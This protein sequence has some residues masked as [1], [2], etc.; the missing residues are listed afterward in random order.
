[1]M[2]RRLPKSNMVE[3]SKIPRLQEAKACGLVRMRARVQSRNRNGCGGN[4]IGYST[5]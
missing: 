3:V 4:A 2:P 5:R 1:M